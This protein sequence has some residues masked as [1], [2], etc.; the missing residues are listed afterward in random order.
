MIRSSQ[1]FRN[2][3]TGSCLLLSGSAYA[4]GWVTTEL[5]ALGG[6]SSVNTAK[7]DSDNS[8]IQWA[9]SGRGGNPTFLGRPISRVTDDDVTEAFDYY[10]RCFM[11]RDGF[12]PDVPMSDPRRAAALPRQR[13]FVAQLLM[14]PERTLRQLVARAQDQQQQ[15]ERQRIAQRS[16]EKQRALEEERAQESEQ[17]RSAQEADER[18]RQTL[19]L[20]ARRRAQAEKFS[21]EA[22]EQAQRDREAAAELSKQ[23]EEEEKALA[24]TKRLADEARRTRQAA[25]QR[26]AQI[27][28]EREASEDQLAKDRAATASPLRKRPDE[29]KHPGPET[30]LV[31]G[32]HEAFNRISTRDGSGIRAQL[33]SCMANKKA[34]CMYRFSET[35]GA[36]AAA[37]QPEGPAKS[38]SIMNSMKSE[39]AIDSA[40]KIYDLTVQ[41]V[42]PDMDAEQRQA[43]VSYLVRSLKNKDEV[44]LNSGSVKFQMNKLSSLGMIMFIAELDPS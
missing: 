11:K 26:L 14:A 27:R 25:E 20:E 39:E 18:R 37:D 12:S 7:I 19:A 13:E 3:L 44:S 33:K 42:A 43:A 8:N 4:G 34:V 40:L 10:R 17:R 15:E 41:V 24:E 38:I 6:C 31:N 23:A 2:L 29:D 32:F 35:A 28:R 1:S 30:L 36:T 21:V 9:L 5:D 16:V 22:K